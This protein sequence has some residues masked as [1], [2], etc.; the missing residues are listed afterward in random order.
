MNELKEFLKEKNIHPTSFK[1]LGK[2]IIIEDINGKYVIRLNS[3]NYD[4]YKYLLSRK[5]YA[6]PKCLS[7]K[8]DMHE[9]AQYISD[10][11]INNDQ[12][13]NDLLFLLSELHLKTTY[14]KETCLQEINNCYE[15]IEK[16]L[17]IV[18]QYYNDLNDQIDHEMFLSPSKYLLVRNI[19]LF[20]YCLDEALKRIKIWKE[21]IIKEKQGRFS[22]I[23]NNIDYHH[24]LINEQKYLI[25][26]DKAYFGLPSDDLESFYRKY[27]ELLSLEETL[28]I[29]NSINKLSLPEETY[30]LVKL[31]IP[32]IIELG[33]NTYL[34]T[35]EVF[36]EINYLQK[37]FDYYQQKK[38]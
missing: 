24:L 10:V 23:Y 16:H 35:Q 36:Q 11:S 27:Y 1:N 15:K 6:F 29:Y 28:K 25:G 38:K 20:Y 22:L 3:N 8:E 26:W 17:K 5:F 7:N 33:E 18:Y 2:V 12:K 19:S 37:I 13:I 21:E 31:S 9:I 4:I 34:D 32:K 14:H 30:L